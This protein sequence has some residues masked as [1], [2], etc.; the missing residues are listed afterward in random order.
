M[1]RRRRSKVEEGLARDVDRM[2]GLLR[3]LRL[4]GWSGS[5]VLELHHGGLRSAERRWEQRELVVLPDK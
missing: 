5:L 2:R 1:S 4:S 3:E